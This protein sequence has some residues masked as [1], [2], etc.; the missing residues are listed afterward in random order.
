MV[1][2][3]EQGSYFL[4]GKRESKQRETDG[5]LRLRNALYLAVEFAWETMGVWLTVLQYRVIFRWFRG[6]VCTL[7]L[8][9]MSAPY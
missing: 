3:A 7:L 4:F 9:P 1:S 6:A 8:R 5:S 2:G